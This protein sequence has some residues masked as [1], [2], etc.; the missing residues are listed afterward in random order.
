M[1]VNVIHP[2]MIT[3]PVGIL[4]FQ[5]A[6]LL[7]PQWLSVFQRLCL[8]RARWGRKG[9]EERHAGARELGARDLRRDAKKRTCPEFATSN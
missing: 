1:G 7:G 6:V 3:M 2:V 4:R 8:W 9:Y 5:G